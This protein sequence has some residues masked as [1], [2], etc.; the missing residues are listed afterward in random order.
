MKMIHFESKL[1]KV[2]CFMNRNLQER[3]FQCPVE[4]HNIERV[5][6]NEDC[7]HISC[8]VTILKDDCI[9]VPHPS[10]QKSICKAQAPVKVVFHI[11]AECRVI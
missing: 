7:I 8:V 4:Q 11:G 1:Q 3:G 6:S 5:T 9:E 2:V 10:V